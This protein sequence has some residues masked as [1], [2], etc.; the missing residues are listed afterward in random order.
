MAGYCKIILIGNLGRDPEMRYTPD[1]LAVANFSIAVNEK[2]K[3]ED[4]TQ[5]YRIVAFGKLG[6]TCGEYLAKG[7]QVF[8]EGRLRVDEWV[9]NEGK[10]RY[11][12]EVIAQNMQMLGTKA[13]AM[14]GGGGYSGGYGGGAAPRQSSQPA[15]SQSYSQ[16]PASGGGE[17]E[18]PDE[19]DI[20]F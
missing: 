1:G 2:F 8:I 15:P 19:D 11:T 10:N 16:P 14:G 3:G 9:D 20:P 4:R 5:W 17:P 12:L 18:P 7:K 6:E 13:D